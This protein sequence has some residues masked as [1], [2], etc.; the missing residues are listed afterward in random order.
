MV[1]ITADGRDITKDEWRRIPGFKRY[2]INEDG[3]VYSIQRGQLLKEHENPK[4]GT[5]FYH[6]YTDS[7]QKTTRTFQSLKDLAFP[8]QAVS[9]PEP[10]KPKVTPLVSYRKNNEWRPIPGWR[11]YQIHPDGSIRLGNER[12]IVKPKV[13]SITGVKY[14][15]L[16]D[17]DWQS[18]SISVDVL[19]EL[20]MGAFEEENSGLIW[21][22]VKRNRNAA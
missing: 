8:E 16:K 9:K 14:I 17:A 13:N 19:M 3:D 11:S 12:R 10:K 18:W 22:H 2:K 20:A 15:N 21:D 7:G 5:F 4:T 1:I 6:V